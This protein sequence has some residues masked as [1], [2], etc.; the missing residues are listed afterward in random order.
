MIIPTRR[1]AGAQRCDRVHMFF[2]DDDAASNRIEHFLRSFEM[3]RGCVCAGSHSSHALPDQAR[4]VR[5]C[6]DDRNRFTESILHEFRCHTCGNRDDHVLRREFA[7]NVLQYGLNDHRL[8]AQNH[9]TGT[10]DGLLI[11]LVR[12]NTVLFPYERETLRMGVCGNE[13]IL[14]NRLGVDQSPD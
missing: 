6:A 13:L 3:R 2:V 8:N 11:G 12:L 7:R 10:T 5:H 1:T 9:N 14:L 4:G